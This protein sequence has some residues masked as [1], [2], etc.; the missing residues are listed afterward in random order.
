MRLFLIL[1]KASL[2]SQA[3]YKFDFFINIL[4]NILGLL[5]DFIIV[6][7][8]LLRF[9]SIEG[10]QLHEIALMYAI[11]E[12]G[13][14]M[15]RFIGDGFNKFEQLILTGKFDTLLIRPASSLLQVMLQKIDFKRLGM[16]AQAVAVGIWGLQ[17]SSF[18]DNSFYMYLPILL[19]SSVIINIQISIILAAVAFWTGK[20]EDIIILGHYSTR[21]AAKYPAT[22]YHNLFS[23]ILTF[24]IPFYSVTYYP[25]LY[26]TGKSGNILYLFAPFIGIAVM[27]PISYVI[28]KSGVKRYSSTG[29]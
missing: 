6:A 2:K 19:L 21:T 26:Y 27:T 20:N 3:Q 23:H 29:T 10:W 22:I 1:F 9:K 8:I 5:G 7:F 13:F 17:S 24:V 25:M 12:F 28:W 11:I 16:V 14:G 18:V 15:Y 4:G